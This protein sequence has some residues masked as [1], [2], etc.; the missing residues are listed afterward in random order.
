MAARRITESQLWRTKV[1][2]AK[3]PPEHMRAYYLMA[4]D[5]DAAWWMLTALVENFAESNPTAARLFG[6]VESIASL[7]C[8]GVVYLLHDE[9]VS[10][11]A[12]GICGE[13]FIARDV[14]MRDTDFHL[15]RLEAMEWDDMIAS[16]FHVALE[17]MGLAEVVARAETLNLAK[18]ETLK[19]IRNVGPEEIRDICPSLWH[20]EHI[21]DA[22][23]Y[24]CEAVGPDE[25]ELFDR[26][27]DELLDR[28]PAELWDRHERQNDGSR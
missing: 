6:Q 27:E 28:E 1:H 23:L 21:V 24:I 9:S 17:S 15:W 13:I 19:L 25:G 18:A 8:L 12:S 5:M 4:D 16:K 10:P 3:H 11:I 26:F 14:E 20:V 2:H 7:E 22:P